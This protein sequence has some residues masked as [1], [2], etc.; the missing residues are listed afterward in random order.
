LYRDRFV[1]L[2]E[3]KKMALSSGRAKY[4]SA[5]SLIVSTVFFILIL[6]IGKWS[7][8]GPISSAGFY[9][10]STTV[11]WFVLLIQFYQRTLAE[12]EKLDIHQ[13]S[14]DQRTRTIFEQGKQDEFF[15]VAQKRLILLEKWFIPA[16]AA[17]IAAYQI[18]IGL[19]LLYQ[20]KNPSQQEIITK[21]PLL[22]ALFM[23]TFAFAAF[24]LS[25]YA[26]GMATQ[27]KYKPLRAGGSS[28]LGAAILCFLLAVCLA[29]A[30]KTKMPLQVFAYVTPSLLII[31]GVETALNTILD[32]YRPR[33]QGRYSRAA[34]DSRLLGIINEPGGILNT[35]AGAIDYQ[36]GFKVS[37]TWFY[38]LLEEAIAPL[39]LLSALT[40]YA[41]SC[42]VV[43]NPNE[44]AIVERF[45]NPLTLSN[46]ARLLEAGIAFKLP[47][48]ID[49]AYKY[50]TEKIE[51]LYIGYEPRID[52]KTGLPEPEQ[53]LLWGKEHFL[54]EESVMVA[55]R[56]T[57]QRQTE[58]TVPVS[59]IIVNIPVQYK[60]KNLYEFL[61][62][63]EDPKKLLEAICY[64]ELARFA[65]SAT[66]EVETEQDI[67]KSVLGAGKTIIK[68]TLTEK[69]RQKADQAGLGIEIVFVGIQGIHPPVKV[70]S[71]YQ[72][73][74][75]AVQKKHTEILY[76]HTKKNIILSRLNLRTYI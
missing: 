70:A 12:Q 54:K 29:I 69:I 50:P 11:I 14:S 36:F 75:G 56:Q 59:L 2:Q 47:W 48:P 25:R 10:L 31:L 72:Q 44:Q 55:S 71:D 73:V 74:A 3:L 35:V 46:D 27:R 39:I 7:G 18:C 52:K 34:F 60:V 57:G 24:L 43:V 65:A 1:L 21:Q 22:C 5:A 68:R 62:N 42:I 40:L 38:K 67:D 9:L 6:I 4:L 51:Q 64:R 63:H 26:T 20:L 19:F 28:L 23:T 53:Q 33:I 61:Y 41:L 58:G 45:G 66:V 16:F 8:F 15:A 32:I 17:V 76:A 13:L 49:I 37:Q 30:S